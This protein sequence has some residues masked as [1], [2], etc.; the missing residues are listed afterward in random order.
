MKKSWLFL[1][2]TI[3]IVV[4]LI[5]LSSF[6]NISERASVS[7]TSAVVVGKTNY[8]SLRATFFIVADPGYSVHIIF[9]NGT[10]QQITTY[11]TFE[12]FLPKTEPEQ[13]SDPAHFYM[14]R[15]SEGVFVTNKEPIDIA[16]ASNVDESFFTYNLGPD[17]NGE[18]VF[19]WFKIQGN[20]DV[21]V[22]IYGVTI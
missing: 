10:E 5:I 18:V 1:L 21:T 2:L 17:P 16:V 22:S 4:Q 3:T 14:S 7:G 12:V 6:N 8:V 19:Y 15:D 20:A 9:P 11:H 13:S